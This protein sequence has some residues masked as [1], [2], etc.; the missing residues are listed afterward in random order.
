V[1]TGCRAEVLLLYRSHPG[2]DVVPSIVRDMQTTK[3][4]LHKVICTQL[5]MLNKTSTHTYN[6]PK[7]ENAMHLICQLVFVSITQKL[8]T[9][10]ANDTLATQLTTVCVPDKIPDMRLSAGFK[11]AAVC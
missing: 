11:S 6:P 1:T 4:E 2:R 9:P 5:E 10:T 3:G 8:V 7:K